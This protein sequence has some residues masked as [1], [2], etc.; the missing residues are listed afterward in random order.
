MNI[1]S[2]MISTNLLYKTSNLSIVGKLEVFMF[3]VLR[4]KA[5][6]NVIS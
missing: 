1:L 3:L 5:S 4:V 6:I 2:K